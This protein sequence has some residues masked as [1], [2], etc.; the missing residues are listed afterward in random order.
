MVIG[1]NVKLLGVSKEQVFFERSSDEGELRER[2]EEIAGMIGPDKDWMF[3][4]RAQGYDEFVALMKRGVFPV[5]YGLI[6]H[7]QLLANRAARGLDRPKEAVQVTL[8]TPP[9]PPMSAPVQVAPP[10]VAAAAPAAAAG[11]GLPTWMKVAI[12]LGALFV[13]GLLVRR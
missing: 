6:S 1:E 10:P 9:A 4:A 11:D 8:P 2:W 5:K 13:I 7:E 3:D 12:G